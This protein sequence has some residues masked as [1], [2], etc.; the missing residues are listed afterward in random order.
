M[1]TVYSVTGT[2]LISTS[3]GLMLPSSGG[4]ASKLD[5]N[6]LE[7]ITFNMTGAVTPSFTFPVT[8]S[9][10][11]KNVTMQWD[12]FTKTR[13]STDILFS[14]QTVPTRFL[15]AFG[16]SDSPLWAA[17]ITD[18]PNM[19]S[20]TMGVIGFGQPGN[21]NIVIAPSTLSNFGN[22]YVGIS[23]SSITYIVP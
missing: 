4:T 8:F 2:G 21:A 23:N 16:N 6:G 13:T 11:G 3:D 10:V 5:Y 1:G 17:S 18:G 7:T 22:T 12:G 20:F 9:R 19:T 14:I 15:P